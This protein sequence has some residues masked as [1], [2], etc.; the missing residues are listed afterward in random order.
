M[1]DQKL[2]QLATLAAASADDI[3]YVVDDPGGS[4]VAK[5]I[6]QA[7]LTALQADQETGT[8]LVNWVAP[9]VQQYH[10]SAAKCWLK[11]G[12]TGN[13]LASYNITSLTDTGTGVLT[14][15]IGTDFSGADWACL[16]TIGF[17]STTLAQSCTYD[18]QAA[19]SVVLRSVVEA[20]SSADPVSWSFAGFGD[21]A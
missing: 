16:A 11:A 10:P 3:F 19:G 21:Q 18:S 8:S 14:I 12:L 5:K 20:G 9:G 6:T 15:T 4:P 7:A 13:I 1:A 2:T 17:A